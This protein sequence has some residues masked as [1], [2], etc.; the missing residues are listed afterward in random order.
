MPPRGARPN[1]AALRN[2]E[3][4]RLLFDLQRERAALTV[5]M[6]R[7]RGDGTAGRMRNV[8]AMLVALLRL[9]RANRRAAAIVDARPPH[10]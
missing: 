8:M 7:L 5:A 10:R 2:A 3:L 6:M 4:E 1:G 9:E